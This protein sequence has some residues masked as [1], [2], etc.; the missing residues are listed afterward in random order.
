MREFVLRWLAKL[1]MLPDC[2]RLVACSFSYGSEA[3]K[4]FFFSRDMEKVLNGHLSSWW[5][6]LD[7]I[8]RIFKCKI[9]CFS[10]FRSRTWDRC[11][12]NMAPTWRLSYKEKL[13]TREYPS[14]E[15]NYCQFFVDGWLQEQ[16]SI[17]SSFCGIKRLVNLMKLSSN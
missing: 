13:M 16:G 9:Q 8:V 5:L 17:F 1:T 14:I 10:S 3:L 7:C 6:V 4:C 12:S 15:A 11:L 2:H